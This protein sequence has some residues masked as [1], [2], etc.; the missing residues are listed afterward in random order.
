MIKEQSSRHG[1]G[2]I[3]LKR[4]PP[5]VRRARQNR[6]SKLA[7]GAS[8]SAHMMESRQPLSPSNKV[9][10]PGDASGIDHTP[11]RHGQVDAGS[12]Q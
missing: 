5:R 1:S 9:H 6:N 11:R 2:T 7:L 4:T 3:V 8:T 12:S 10:C